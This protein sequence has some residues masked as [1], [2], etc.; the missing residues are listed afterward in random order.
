[1][2]KYDRASENRNSGLE[3]STSETVD[4]DIIVDNQ[5]R[6]D[7]Q[8]ICWY[9]IIEFRI[10]IDGDEFFIQKS[11]ATK[12]ELM[13]YIE[14]MIDHCKSDINLA[15]EAIEKAEQIKKMLNKN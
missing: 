11:S 8:T 4:N 15:K 13:E 7:Y 3:A 10:R 14:K 9:E 6:T 12:E 2:K 5:I 1:M